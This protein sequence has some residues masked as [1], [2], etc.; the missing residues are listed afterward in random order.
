MSNTTPA[1]VRG[2]LPELLF[3]DEDLGVLDSG[4]NLILK[5]SAMEVPTIL[6]DAT[7]LASGVDYTFIAPR[8]ITLGT[9]ATSENYTVHSHLAFTDAKLTEFINSSDRIIA[10]LFINMDAPAAEYLSDWSRDLTAHRV[11]VLTA[12]GNLDKVAWARSFRSMALDA[13]T[14]YKENSSKGVFND[15]EVTRDDATSINAYA[16]DQ[17]KVKKYEPDESYR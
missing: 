10:N 9:A 3:T 1:L 2:I 11:L 5:N 4:T 8:K 14:A 12:R 17:Q 13:I 6:R 15:S 16:L 7:T